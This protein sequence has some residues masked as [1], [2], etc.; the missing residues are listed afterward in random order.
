MASNNKPI[1]QLIRQCDEALELF[2][3]NFQ[4]FDGRLYMCLRDQTPTMRK[5]RAARDMIKEYEN[6]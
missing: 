6:G 4:L 1:D 2:G 3:D 5:I